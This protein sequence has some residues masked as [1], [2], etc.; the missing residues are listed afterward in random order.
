L[1]EISACSTEGD[2]RLSKEGHER[3]GYYFRAR[4]VFGDASSARQ[5]TMLA[6]V[7]VLAFGAPAVVND[8]RQTLTVKN[9]LEES[10]NALAAA[11]AGGL[12]AAR[13]T[14]GHEAVRQQLSKLG[15]DAPGTEVLIYNPD[16]V[17]SLSSNPVLPGARLSTSSNEERPAQDVRSNPNTAAKAELI[18]E[19]INGKDYYSLYRPILNEPT[20]FSCHSADRKILG[21]LVVRTSAG[22]ALGALQTERNINLAGA[23]LGILTV[24]VLSYALF[25]RTVSHLQRMIRKI[26]ETSTTLS[27]ASEALISASNRLTLKAVEMK[28]QSWAASDAARQASDGIGSMA[29]RAEEV[30]AQ[31]AAVSSSSKHISNSMNEISAATASVS[32]NLEAVAGAA[33]QMSGSVSMVAA[34]IEEMHTSLNEVSKSAGRGAVVTREASAMVEKTS[35]IMKT[36]GDSAKEIDDVVEL[37]KGVASQTN[38]LALNAAIEAAGAGDAGKGFAVV[39]NEVKDLARQTARSTE[40]IRHKVGAIQ[41][42]TDTAVKAIEDILGVIVEI[43]SIM[44]SIAATVEEQTATTNEISRSVSEVALAADSVSKSVQ[45]GAQGAARSA[46]SVQEAVHAEMKIARHIEEVAGSARAIARD[47]GEAAGATR[48]ATESVARVDAEVEDVA[49][50]SFAAYEAAEDLVNLATRLY[51]LVE[52]N[53]GTSLKAQKQVLAALNELSTH[54]DLQSPDEGAHAKALMN[55]LE[56]TPEACAV[57]TNRLDGSIIFS[58]PPAGLPNANWR[59]WFKAA[60]A[61]KTYISQPYRSALGGVCVTMSMPLLDG[62]GKVIAVLAADLPVGQ[63]EPLETQ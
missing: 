1:K 15:S 12:G 20:C 38:L 55:W 24:L 51:K 49:E 42:S 41:N 57:F 37:I 61:G 7:V 14:D 33:E 9:R 56:K 58:E 4:P 17:I 46:M 11:V 26:N 35:E 62:A 32:N 23:G 28:Q 5:F 3:R 40:T 27:L 31:T 54:P 19:R 45:E 2:A 29:A 8:R 39:A 52:G 60:S 18:E 21:G 22:K 48:T 50:E 53:T 6:L 25:N 36:L 44:S 59:G 10:G 13:S 43:N 47:A 30:S 16:F 34:A 63:T